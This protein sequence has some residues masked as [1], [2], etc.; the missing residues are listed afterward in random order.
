MGTVNADMNISE[1]STLMRNFQKEQMKSEM[2]QE[3]V[4]DAMDMGD[5]NEE[6]DDVYNQIL[7]EVGFI[8]EDGAIVGVGGIASKA[9]A[10]GVQEEEKTGEVDDLEK[11]LAALGDIDDWVLETYGILSI[12]SELEGDRSKS[13]PSVWSSGARIEFYS[14]W[15]KWV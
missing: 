15:P 1:I 7:G 2:K 6:A 5:V 12:T 9:P 14:S 8:M 10:M 13:T 3:M 4:A 11:R